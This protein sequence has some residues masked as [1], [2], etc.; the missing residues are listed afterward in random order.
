MEYV[1]INDE[2]IPEDKKISYE[3]FLSRLLDGTF[4]GFNLLFGNILDYP[5]DGKR[6][7]G[8]LRYYQNKNLGAM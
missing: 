2:D 7:T 4:K 5:Q 8:K 3:A 1:K 6:L